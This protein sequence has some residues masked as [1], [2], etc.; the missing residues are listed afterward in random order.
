MIKNLLLVSA[1]MIPVIYSHIAQASCDGFPVDQDRGCNEN[2]RSACI[3]NTGCVWT[4]ETPI[5]AVCNKTA[6]KISIGVQFVRN[7][8]NKISEEGW[9]NLEVG[10]CHDF[11]V[12]DSSAFSYFAQAYGNSEA[13]WS[14][15]GDLICYDPSGNRYQRTRN[16][17]DW[18]CGSYA[19]IKA[20]ETFPV[21]GDDVIVTKVIGQ[22]RIIQNPNP[23]SEPD[24]P[25]DP[26]IPGGPNYTNI[27]LAWT[28]STGIWATW[29]ADNLVDAQAK[30]IQE[31]Q[32]KSGETCAL[33][34]SSSSERYACIALLKDG[35]YLVAQLSY[36]DKE[37]AING[38]LAECNKDGRSCQ[39]VDLLCNG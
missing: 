13:V 5:V 2:T 24:A 14:G 39:L 21:K 25:S 10:Q 19:D 7:G 11:D 4:P 35:R 15:Q 6:E 34:P 3:A 30:A 28:G 26:V 32:N 33:G 17:T 37:E 18:T 38:A 1:L 27:A 29:T 16:A 9:W 31:C 23:P 36:K 8:Y 20:Y 22:P 12:P